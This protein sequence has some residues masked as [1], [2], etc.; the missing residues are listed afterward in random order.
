MHRSSAPFSSPVLA[1]WLFADLFLVLFVIGLASLPLKSHPAHAKA[2]PSPST[3]RP[4]PSPTP[5]PTATPVLDRRPLTVTVNVPPA[6]L[7][8]PASRRA[9]M[10]QIIA[11]LD[12]MLRPRHLLDAK[13]G[14]V[15]V[16][17][18]GSEADINNAVAEAKIVVAQLPRQDKQFAQATGN[19]YWS[20]TGNGIELTIFFFARD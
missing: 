14:V 1:G 16:F 15:L 17:A 8:D 11:G 7:A 18:A 4:S 12:R 3:S 6:S 2:S 5:T 19:G 10:R 9:A 20:G 13:V